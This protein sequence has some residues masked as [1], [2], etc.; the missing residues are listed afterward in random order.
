M[1]QVLEAS[2]AKVSR[3]YEYLVNSAYGADFDNLK[4][5]GQPWILAARDWQKGERVL[6]VGGAYSDLPIYLQQTYGCEVWV[7]DDFG[8]DVQDAQWTRGRSP[9][10]HIAAHPN[11]KYVLERVGP[12]KRSS[13]PEGTFDVVYSLSA[14]EHAGSQQTPAVW[15][16]MHR[17]LKPG[18]ELLHEID[19][20]FPS[21]AGLKGL[22]RAWAFDLLFP[23]LP[24]SFRNRH[25]ISTPLAYLRTAFRSLG[26]PARPTG[27]LSA[28]NMALDPDIL[29]EAYK[30]G[31]YRLTR[32]HEKDYRYQR[33]GALLIHVKKV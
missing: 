25:S 9:Q 22:L 17:L 10:E 27:N 11:I 20:T 4:G 8:L 33:V 18:G 21:N 13:L 26:I 2:L 15:M 31:L 12:V 28:L 24:L 23:L 29:A 14:L 6:D 30:H 5:F 19:I 3:L 7:A 16:H 32:D 1:Y